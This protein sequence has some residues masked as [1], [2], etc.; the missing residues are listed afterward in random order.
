MW[1]ERCGE[2]IEHLNEAEEKQI[3]C[4]SIS[5]FSDLPAA[6]LVVHGLAA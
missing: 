3:T 4:L 2:D 1:K 5:E 6:N